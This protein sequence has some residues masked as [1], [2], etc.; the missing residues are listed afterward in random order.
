MSGSSISSDDIAPLSM[1]RL[2]AR[3]FVSG[4]IKF[5]RQEPLTLVG[6]GSAAS[7]TVGCSARSAA[8]CV[9]RVLA[10]RIVWIRNANFPYFFKIIISFLYADTEASAAF[11]LLAPGSS[12]SRIDRI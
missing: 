10:L 8:E 6:G 12:V 5:L 4:F 3:R 9:S 1:P 7:T 11:T 2:K